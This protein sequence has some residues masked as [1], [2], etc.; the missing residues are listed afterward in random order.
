MRQSTNTYFNVFVTG[1]FSSGK[2]QFIQ[3]IS[4][5]NVVNTEFAPID[6]YS[7]VHSFGRLTINEHQCYIFLS[8]RTHDVLNL[9]R[10]SLMSIESES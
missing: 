8:H 9:M 5:I 6:K 3:S 7:I 4:E 10:A 1:A 2:T